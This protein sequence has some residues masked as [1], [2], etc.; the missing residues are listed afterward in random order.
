MHRPTVSIIK[1]GMSMKKRTVVAGVVSILSVT[2]ALGSVAL[3]ASATADPFNKDSGELYAK[4][5]QEGALVVYSVWD[6]EHIVAI[7][8]AFSKRYPGIKTNYWQGRNTEIV[9]RAMT[10]YHAGGVC[11]DG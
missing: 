8:D 5:K 11:V 4:A 10:E 9:T 1:G 2:V 7:L 3:G 6:V